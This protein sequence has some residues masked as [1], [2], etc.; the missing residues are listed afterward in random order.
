MAAVY[1]VGKQNKNMGKIFI[2]FIFLF[3]S[4]LLPAQDSLNSYPKE[5]FLQRVKNDGIITGKTIIEAYK[6]PFHWKKKEWLMTGSVLAVSAAA[7]LLDKPIYNYYEENSGKNPLIATIATAGDFMGQPENNYPFMMTLWGLGVITKNEWLRDTGILLTASIT[8]SGLVQTAL[9]EAVGRA[10]PATGKGP[11]AF[12]PFGGRAYH[13][14]PSGHTMLALA[15][16]YVLA[17]QIDF[18]PLRIIVFTIPV[19]TGFSRIHD[20]AHFLSDIILGSA[21]GIA[22][23]EAVMN[24]YP[25][26]KAEQRSKI[27]LVP[28]MRGLKLAYRF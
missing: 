18:M 17:H 6:R 13:S 10:R 4:T 20:G 15:S 8:S 16:A 21:I 28:T 19:I 24:L 5:N 11:Y 3:S 25:N 2:C 12:K 22:F 7:S 1:D 14:F 27:S 9:K 23:A 26:I